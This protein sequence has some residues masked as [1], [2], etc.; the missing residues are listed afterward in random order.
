MIFAMIAPTSSWRRSPGLWDSWEDDALIVDKVSGRFADPDKVHRLDYHGQYFQTR[1]P[2]TV[3]RSAQGHPVLLQAGAS[4]RGMAFAGRWAELIFAAYPNLE[5]GRKQY[6]A[7]RAAAEAAGRD[8]DSLRIAP[9]IGITVAESAD[10]AA[11]KRA[12][13]ESMARPIDGLTLLCEVLNV[14]FAKRPL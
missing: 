9:A 2:L 5:G 12:Y 8:P 3:P 1:G 4:G 13:H 7:L 10:Q 6:Q 11:E 14:D